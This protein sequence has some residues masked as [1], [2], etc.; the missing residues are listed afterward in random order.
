ME[1]SSN[2]ANYS[3]VDLTGDQPNKEN[4]S[5]QSLTNP[6]IRNDSFWYDYYGATRHMTDQRCIIWH[7]KAIN[8]GTWYV[9]SIGDTRLL[10]LG[11]GDV[12]AVTIVNFNQ[13]PILIRGVLC[14]PKLRINVF[15]IAAATTDGVETIFSNNEVLFYRNSTLELS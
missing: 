5:Y 7:L 12:N 8:S 4:Y 15:F 6:V 11:Q 14:M 13:I 1:T 10:I 9:S 3:Q 2:L